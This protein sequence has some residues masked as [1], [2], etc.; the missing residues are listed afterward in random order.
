MWQ[1][2][3][4]EDGVL[5]TAWEEGNRMGVVGFVG[6]LL[7]WPGFVVVVVVTAQAGWSEQ[8]TGCARAVMHCRG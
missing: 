7:V 5:E 3:F 4:G 2:Y 8:L 6:E 1:V